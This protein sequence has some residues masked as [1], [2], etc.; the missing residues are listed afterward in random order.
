MEFETKKQALKHRDAEHAKGKHT[1]KVFKF[2]GKRKKPFFVGNDS[3]WLSA[4]S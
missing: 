2:A 4:I 3:Q 1:V